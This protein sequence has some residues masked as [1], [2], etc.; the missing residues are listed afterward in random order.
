MIA[1]LQFLPMIAMI[2]RG[3]FRFNRSASV[4]SLAQRNRHGL[5]QALLCSRAPGGLVI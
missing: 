5:I 2:V 3:F 4:A 1:V